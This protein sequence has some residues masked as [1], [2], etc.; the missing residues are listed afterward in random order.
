MSV[1][2]SGPAA[3]G[4]YSNKIVAQPEAAQQRGGCHAVGN[5][6]WVK[7]EGLVDI[8]SETASERSSLILGYVPSD[9]SQ[10]PGRKVVI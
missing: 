7:A 4:C 3:D 2:S 8:M 5:A 9:P 6:E 10:H 1:A